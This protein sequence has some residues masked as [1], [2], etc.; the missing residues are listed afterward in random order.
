VITYIC[1]WY[2]NG[3]ASCKKHFLCSTFP[4]LQI[5]L[6]S[7]MRTYVCLHMYVCI[8]DEFMYV[9]IY[10]FVYGLRNSTPTARTLCPVSPYIGVLFLWIAAHNNMR[11]LIYEAF[12]FFFF[13][14]LGPVCISSGSTSAFKAYCALYEALHHFPITRQWYVT[15]YQIVTNKAF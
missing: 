8:C 12:F 5:N 4:L 1:D 15:S 7:G 13:F 6:C 9:L 3:A 10:S 2:T 11:R 14:F